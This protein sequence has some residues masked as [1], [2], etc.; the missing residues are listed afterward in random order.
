MYENDSIRKVA[1]ESFEETRLPSRVW[2]G[3]GAA[4]NPVH[5]PAAKPLADGYDGWQTGEQ[6]APKTLCGVDRVCTI[7]SSDDLPDQS[8]EHS[9]NPYRGCEHGCVYCYA[10]PTHSWHGLS[11]GL[12]FETRILH[13]P[14]AAQLLRK[15]IARP[16][17]VP[18][19]I[20]LG[21]TTDG[22]QPVERW[23]RL[24]RDIL[25]VLRETRHPVSIITKSALITRDIDLLTAMAQDG[26]VHVMLSLTTLDGELSRRLEPRA[27]SPD[28]RLKAITRLADAGV[29]V[30][31]M[32]APV[33]PGLNDHELE[34][35]LA[36]AR[37]AGAGAAEYGLLRLP[38]EVGELFRDWLAHHAPDKASRIMTILYD[39][40]SGHSD[41]PRFGVRM[42]GLG[43]FA[44]L[45]DQRFD[46]ACGRLGLDGSLPA[47]DGSRFTPGRYEYPEEIPD[48]QLS[49]F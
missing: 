23:L 16:G 45:L 14:D 3:R 35:V 31:V 1:R 34:P 7:L 36:A 11:P 48:T 26:L 13:R 46:A 21:T 8:I 15:E 10:R 5:R 49:L 12:D 27:A 37:D 38:G 29:P 22:W 28:A 47:L 32:F 24:S 20:A 41:D 30:G 6:A 4:L 25:E 2:K 33:I 17:H 39:M 18:T 19:P 44:E 42:R 40:R 43:H 9:V